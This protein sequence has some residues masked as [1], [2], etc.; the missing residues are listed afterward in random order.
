MRFV[1]RRMAPVTI[2][3]KRTKTSGAG[4]LTFSG[5]QKR[6]IVRPKNIIQ[7]VKKKTKKKNVSFMWNS[8]LSL[9]LGKSLVSFSDRTFCDIFSFQ[10]VGSN[11]K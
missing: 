1:T 4:G 6:M 11:K 5:Y 10:S 9:K 3:T 7:T 2:T 8:S